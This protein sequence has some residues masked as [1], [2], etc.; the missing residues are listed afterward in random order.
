MDIE[1]NGAKSVE[2]SE[3]KAKEDTEDKISEVNE[4]VGE[5]ISGE[6]IPGE[7]IST[8]KK[9]VITR[10]DLKAIFQKFGN[11]KVSDNSLLNSL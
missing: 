11:V 10:E 2:D 7:N 4:K 5:E 6:D 8:A 9:D 1:A 3:E